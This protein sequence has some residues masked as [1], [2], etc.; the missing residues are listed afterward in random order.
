MARV[1][2]EDCLTK[3]ENRFHLV[4]LAAKMAR[5]LALGT[6]ESVLPWDNHKATVLAL[7]TIAANGG[8]PANAQQE[9]PDEAQDSPEIV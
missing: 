1:T 2:V 5:Q 4:L 8:V 7:K 6:V 3:V 9:T